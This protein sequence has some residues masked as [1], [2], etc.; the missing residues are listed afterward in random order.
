MLKKFYPYKY[1][2][3]VFVIDYKKLFDIGYRGL[4][5]DIDSTL[6]P[7]G[8][9]ST[10]EVDKLFKEINEIGFKTVLLSNNTTERIERFMKNI[11]SMYI[12]DARKPDTCNYLKAVSMLGIEKKEA[13]VIGDQ[14]FTDIL[15]ANRSGIDSILVDFIPYKGETKL[16]KR[17]RLE[18]FIL[19]FYKLNKRLNNRIGDIIKETGIDNA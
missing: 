7:H 4:I 5:F 2:E 17:R 1:V 9:D 18:R 8:N 13:L 11:D 14:I 16:G 19:M 15:G 12:S 10:M 6:V 3:S